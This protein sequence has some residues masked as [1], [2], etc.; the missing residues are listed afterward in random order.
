MP[1]SLIAPAP[2]PG[3]KRR[4]SKTGLHPIPPSADEITLNMPRLVRSEAHG[5]PSSLPTPTSPAPAPATETAATADLSAAPAAP[6]VTGDG[7][8]AAT[9]TAD[10][11]PDLRPAPITAPTASDAT[12]PDA[13][14][15]PAATHDL[16]SEPA[17]TDLSSEPAAS[18]LSPGTSPASEPASP[19][20][21]SQHPDDPTA[22]AASEDSDAAIEAYLQAPQDP[23]AL[24]RLRAFNDEGL[25][26]LA[27][28]FPGP[29][30]PGSASD[31]R[32]FPP[33]S[34]HGPLLRACVEIGPTLTPFILPLVD[35][36]RPQIRFYAA[37][38]FQDLRD[39][40]CMR[41]LAAHAFDPDPDVRLI[42][43][44]VLESYN[45]VAG[46]VEATD[47]VRAE[48]K[49]K[50]RER[51]LLASEAA[52]TLR[53]TRAVAVLIDILSVRDKQLRETALESLCSITAKHHGY[54]P[55]KWKAW[56]AEHGQQTRVEW[57]LDALRHRDT[58]VRRW[59]SDELVR[60]TGHRISPPQGG[61]KPTA[62]YVLQQWTAW[63]EAHA[64]ELGER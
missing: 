22:G 34:A 51:A 63:W 5:D 60:I 23:G 62:K 55:A 59:A 21:A 29:I 16:S 42:A 61:E 27:A 48:L 9:V 33:P 26:R 45:R 6:S 7:G 20:P 25:A 47:L 44:R 15:A 35:H 41:P 12:A 19:Q 17:T 24:A 31:V 28:R 30:D 52:G 10:P 40:R 56:Y 46:F 8:P 3:A 49:S 4:G 37:F 18:D 2:L 57:V 1:A 36:P 64:S 39:P 53:D 13:S 11:S 50:D 14:E 58:A 38:L 43:T 32:S 54:R